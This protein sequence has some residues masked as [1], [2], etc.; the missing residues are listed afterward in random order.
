MVNRT[1]KTKEVIES[2]PAAAAEK[3]KKHRKKKNTCTGSCDDG[4]ECK[5]VKKRVATKYGL[6]VKEHY[7]S[8]RD[9][10]SKERFKAIAKKWAEHKSKSTKEV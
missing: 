7:D 4:K 1:K 2:P 6:F 10:P 9:L 5:C 3:V 8:V